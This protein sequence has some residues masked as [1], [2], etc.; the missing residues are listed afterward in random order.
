VVADPAE[1][2]GLADW[3]RRSRIEG[4]CGFVIIWVVVGTG[5]CRGRI[6]DGVVGPVER[7]RRIRIRIVAG[8]RVVLA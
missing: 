4:E 2:S 7:A 6:T 5:G 8:L 3:G 1:A